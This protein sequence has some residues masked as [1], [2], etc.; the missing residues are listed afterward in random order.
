MN[1]CQVGGQLKCPLQFSDVIVVSQ[2]SLEAIHY[3]IGITL[4]KLLN[5]ARL[6]QSLKHSI[7]VM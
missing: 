5:Y 6:K 1:G 7:P 2:L 4:S 3:F